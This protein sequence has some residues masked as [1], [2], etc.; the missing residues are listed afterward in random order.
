[1]YVFKYAFKSTLTFFVWSFVSK[2]QAVNNFELMFIFL[3]NL[4]QKYEMNWVFLSKTMLIEYF[5]FRH[6]HSRNAWTTVFTFNEFS[7][8]NFFFFERRFITIMMCSYVRSLRLH[9]EKLIIK[10]IDM[11]WKY[12][13]DMSNE[14]NKFCLTFLYVF[15]RL[16][17]W[18]IL[19]YRS[20]MW[21]IRDQ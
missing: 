1:M 10:S 14:F 11:F 20:T 2:C 5:F 13:F 7:A 17:W 18:Q 19:T 4:F 8:T 3:Q 16:H 15:V 21:V 6:I 9:F 12:R